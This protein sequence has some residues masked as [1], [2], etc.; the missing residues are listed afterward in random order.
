MS[1]IVL[2][3][4]LEE[5]FGDSG[6]YS[7]FPFTLHLLLSSLIAPPHPLPLS[8]LS[9]VAY[10]LCGT[11]LGEGGAP[12]VG[13]GAGGTSAG[14]GAVARWFLSGPTALDVEVVLS[15]RFSCFTPRGA[16]TC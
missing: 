5:A 6:F 14:T 2:M 1:E 7:H 3:L 13:F 8:H 10:H 12:S 4:M 16:G 9:R 11:R 15:M